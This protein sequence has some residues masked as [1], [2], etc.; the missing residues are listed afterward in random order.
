MPYLFITLFS[1]WVFTLESLLRPRDYSWQQAGRS[2]SPA[3]SPVEGFCL[4]LGVP[5]WVQGSRLQ[6]LGTR[7]HSG[8]GWAP[9]PPELLLLQHTPGYS[10]TACKELLGLYMAQ[11]HCC[12]QNCWAAERSWERAWFAAVL[13]SVLLLSLSDSTDRRSS[14]RQETKAVEDGRANAPYSW[15]DLELLRN[16]HARNYFSKCF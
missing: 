14:R 10:F 12:N 4:R 2:S 3:P 5:W 15:I 6:A 8:L 11:K 7:D 1:L 13:H 16:H 9:H